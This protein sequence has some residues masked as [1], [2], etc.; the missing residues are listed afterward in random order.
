MAI[1]ILTIIAFLFSFHTQ[2]SCLN[3]PKEVFYNFE[4]DQ[5]SI[6]SDESTT[7]DEFEEQVQ[8][9]P[10][11]NISE[12]FVTREEWGAR[13]PK[14]WDYLNVIPPT[15][16]VIHH[17]AV[18]GECHTNKQ[19]SKSVK[20]IQNFHMD[21]QK[22]SDIGYNFLIG[23]DGRVYEGRGWEVRG[24]HCPKYNGNSIGICL[25]GNYEEKLPIERM[26]EVAR[27]L[28]RFGVAN[29]HV[30]P[31]YRLIGHRQGRDTECPGDALYAEIQKW[32]QWDPHPE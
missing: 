12:V 19:C 17:S 20:G 10:K 28:I 30:V 24:A 26:L 9:Y 32:P 31:D 27:E 4:E 15:Y 29:E 25:I 23:G 7:V 14:A 1:F 22:F 18:P 5:E 13:P 2:F 6:F 8:V 16:V 11:I 21:E 3:Q